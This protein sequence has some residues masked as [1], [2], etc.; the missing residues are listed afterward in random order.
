MK[1]ILFILVT[2]SVAFIF[3]FLFILQN[4][5]SS[6]GIIRISEK[7]ES[8][9]TEIVDDLRDNGEK[10]INKIKIEKKS[11]IELI[12]RVVGKNENMIL[13]FLNN[14]PQELKWVNIYFFDFTG[15]GEM[16][17]VL[18][19]HYLAL[20]AGLPAYN[21]V[22]DQEGNLLFEF[23]CGSSVEIYTEN[24]MDSFWLCSDMHWGSCNDMI[25]HSKITRREG[26]E[27]DFLIAEWDMRRAGEEGLYY[28]LDLSKIEDRVLWA[29]TYNIVAETQRENNANIKEEQFKG[30]F[31]DCES[32]E[33]KEL[34][35]KGS[36]Y[37]GENGI[38]M[39]IEGEGM[40]YYRSIH[41][42]SEDEELTE[43]EYFNVLNQ[44]EIDP[45]ELEWHV[46][47]GF[48]S[49]ANPGEQASATIDQIGI[50]GRTNEETRLIHKILS[51]DKEEFQDFLTTDWEFSH[52]QEAI[53]ITAYDFTGD[54]RDEIIVSK[55]YINNSAEISY[56]FV[57]NR[58]GERVL[59]FV[60]G[61]PLDLQIIENWGEEGI[62]LLY[63]GNHY[64]SH[65]NA[66]IYT[67]IEW[68]EDIIT[69]EV[70]LME[71]DRREGGVEEKEE[72]Y[73]FK[74]FTKEEEEK[75]WRGASGVN[76]LTKMK[77][78][79][80]EEEKLEEYKQLFDKTKTTEVSMVSVILYSDSDG[81]FV[82]YE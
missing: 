30:Y 62:F 47:D 28:I 67:E 15:N 11:E 17:I 65:N 31:P 57:Y 2:I 8:I 35:M 64:S 56:N 81:G 77:E 82:E 29:D 5:E 48:W 39:E 51:S 36:I 38:I 23:F 60:G 55:F 78:Y 37:P 63:H 3:V 40:L 14:Y 44:Y 75:L 70:I 4:D 46:V 26:W 71:L 69:E 80:W 52:A 27:K 12:N 9:V 49:K 32:I 66:N 76:E 6:L 73:I 20:G 72:Y 33:K 53:I 25:L 68:K 34:N 79:V 74:D 7:K 13:D 58:N 50:Q 1:K 21:Y 24:N 43:E 61:H 16:E 19:K 59:E 22:Y 42:G 10:L 18:S 54:G 45:I 41:H